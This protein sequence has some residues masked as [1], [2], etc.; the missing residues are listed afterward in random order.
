MSK[1]FGKLFSPGKL[2]K[3]LAELQRKAAQEPNNYYLL[4]KIG[5]LLEKMG[6]RQE[7]LK[8]YRQ[9]SEKYTQKGFLVQAIAVN[10]LI[11]RLDPTQQEIHDHLAQLYVQRDILAA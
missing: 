1:V 9:A 2:E 5:D 10:K 11:L 4:V 6:R 8:A 3:D 7:A